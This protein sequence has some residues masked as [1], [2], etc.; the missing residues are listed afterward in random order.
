MMVPFMNLNL[1]LTEEQIS[2]IICDI[3]V[4]SALRHQCVAVDS[5]CLDLA[6]REPAELEECLA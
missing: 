4:A 3:P 2:L 5:N 6:P 1:I